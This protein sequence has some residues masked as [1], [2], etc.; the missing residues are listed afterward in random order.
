MIT[1]SVAIYKIKERFDAEKISVNI[2]QCKFAEIS[3][4]ID[5]YKPVLIIP[6]GSLKKEQTKGV[7]IIKG[8]SFITGIDEEKTLDQIVL[9][10]KRSDG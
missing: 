4:Y 1:S 10:L 7:P 9:Y 6:T 2:I 3:G 8:T 5:E